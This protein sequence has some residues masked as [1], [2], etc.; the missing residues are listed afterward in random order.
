M[1]PLMGTIIIG[2]GLLCSGFLLGRTHW[3]NKGATRILNELFHNKLCDP[4]AVIKHL[5]SVGAKIKQ[6]A[7]GDS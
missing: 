1:S 6:N 7:P 2:G 5:Q 3:S 4:A